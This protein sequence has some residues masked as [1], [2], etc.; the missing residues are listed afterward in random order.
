MSVAEKTDPQLWAE[1]VAQVKSGS[2]SGPAGTWNARKA[3]LAVAIYKRRGGKYKSRK[4]RKNSLSQWT[5]EDWG[6]I[7]ERPGNRYLPRKVRESLTP[8]EKR[9]ENRR[10]KSATRSKKQRAPYS[11]SVAAKLRRSRKSRK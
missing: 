7:D 10:K 4:S 3:Q 11:K 2:T 5:E 6:Y 1:V 9:T 8:A